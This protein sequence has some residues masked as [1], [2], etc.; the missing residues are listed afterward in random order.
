M[1]GHSS[2]CEFVSQSQLEKFSLKECFVVTGVWNL[3]WLR[4]EARWGL[5]LDPMVRVD[6]AGSKSDGGNMP[7]PRGPQADDKTQSVRRRV[8]LVGVRDDGR[9]EQGCRFQGVFANE[10]RTD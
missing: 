9:I 10:I 6:D 3:T 1:L 8:R 5:N 4:K 7:L 2:V